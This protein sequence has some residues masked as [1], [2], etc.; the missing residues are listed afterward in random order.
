MCTADVIAR[1]VNDSAFRTQLLI[2]LAE[3]TSFLQQ[4]CTE[5]ASSSYLTIAAGAPNSENQVGVSTAEKMLADVSD[6]RSSFTADRIK[7]LLALKTS[8]RYF[9]RTCSALQGQAGQESKFT[10]SVAQLL[11]CFRSSN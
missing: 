8:A 3:L 2:E 4:R 6:C 9:N 10:R 5:L 7:Q 1:L 11:L